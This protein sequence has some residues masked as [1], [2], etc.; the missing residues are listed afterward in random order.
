M[1]FYPEEILIPHAAMTL[2]RPVKWAEDRREH[3]IAANQ[4]RGQVHDV[5]VAVDADSRILG[6]R[7]HFVH[8][9]GAYTRTGSWCRSSPPRSVPVP[10]ASGT[11][12]S[13]SRWRT[14]T[15]SRSARIAAPGGFV[16]ER[17]IGRIARELGLEPAE[18]RRRNFIQPSEFPWD[19]G[20]TFQDDGPTRYDSGN[21]PAGS[22]WRST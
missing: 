18:V 2:G 20:L 3:L 5:E 6:L 1:F 19:V 11:T 16:T 7:D 9:A 13:S 17:V 22:K 14:P 4:E 8:D 12:P 21:Y 10:T 15:R